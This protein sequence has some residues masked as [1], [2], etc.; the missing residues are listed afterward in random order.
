MKFPIEMF[1]IKASN[2]RIRIP[3]GRCLSKGIIDDLCV[4]CGG[5]GIH[6]R[7]IKVWE[8][9][10]EAVSIEKIDRSHKDEFYKG[11]QV[12]YKNGLRYWED[13]YTFYNDKDGYLHF[14]REEA[15]KECVVRNTGIQDAIAVIK[16]NR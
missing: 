14:T 11:I 4:N 3:C 10:S 5:K 6:Y 1:R 9:E 8:A 13:S 12:Q 15:L 16:K 7:T 2:L